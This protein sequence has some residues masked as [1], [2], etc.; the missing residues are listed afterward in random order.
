[1]RIIRFIASDG[2]TPFGEDHQDGSATIL[3]GSIQQGFEC[4][5]QRV[6][7]KKLLAPLLPTD[8]ICI[9]RN[10]RASPHEEA[11]G[12]AQSSATLQL[13]PD[14]TLEVFLKPSTAVQNPG[15]PIC[16]PRF[17]G[18]LDP[19]MDCEGELAIIIGRGTRNVSEDDALRHVFGYTIANDVTARIFQTPTGP[20]IWMR[21]K[22]FDGFLPIGPAIITADEIADLQLL[23]LRTIIN[24]EVVREGK[25]CQMIRSIPQIIAALSRHMT[26]RSGSLIITG[27][28]VATRPAQILPGH[29]L[30]IEIPPIGRLV[31]F[32]T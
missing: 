26:L 5:A 27:A 32:I 22:G 4:T 16:V 14:S 17:D 20:P 15:D 31:N 9:G 24:G 25:T 10:Y 7:V 8:I 30:E 12:D 28:P 23:D 3:T 1:M 13:E 11:W 19:Q 21:G 29:T 6:A 18:D 2:T